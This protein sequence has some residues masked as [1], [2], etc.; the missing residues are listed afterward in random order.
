MANA[1]LVCSL[2]ILDATIWLHNL[3]IVLTMQ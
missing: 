2:M 1:I 3:K